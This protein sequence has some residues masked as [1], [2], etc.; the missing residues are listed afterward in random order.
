MNCQDKLKVKAHY[1]VPKALTLSEYL[2]F[3]EYFVKSRKAEYL[4]KRYAIFYY[5]RYKKNMTLTD[6]G[7]MSG[8]DHSTIVNAIGRAKQYYNNRDK[9]FLKLS[10]DIGRNLLPEFYKDSEK[11][12]VDN[13]LQ[14][15][16]KES[17]KIMG[18][19]AEDKYAICGQ[20]GDRTF[21]VEGFT[22]FIQK[23]L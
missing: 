20:I 11:M 8:F 2:D 21:T 15:K 4:Y 22:N 23:L 6:I 7:L 14:D 1:I 9:L 12:E 18:V 13:P 17:L 3:Q 16:I 19:D 10:K 5:L